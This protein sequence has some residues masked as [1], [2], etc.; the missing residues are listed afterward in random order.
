MSISTC[1]S[2]TPAIVVTEIT[3]GI[4]FALTTTRKATPAI[5]RI[6]Q[7]AGNLSRRRSTCGTGPT[8]TILRNWRT[9]PRTNPQNAHDAESSSNWGRTGIPSSE[10][11]ICVRNV[12][13][14]RW[15]RGYV[16]QETQ[17]DG[18]ARPGSAQLSSGVRRRTS[19]ENLERPNAIRMGSS[20]GEGEP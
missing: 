18:E 4:L 2:P 10:I 15:K 20:E 16:E 6:A 13:K 11:G 19:A 5:G 9:P 1:F 17:A 12:V 14:L 3:V 8:S 7:N